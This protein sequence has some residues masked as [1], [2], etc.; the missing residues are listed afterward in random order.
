M[1]DRDGLTVVTGIHFTKSTLKLLN[2]ITFLFDP[3]W[4]A[5]ANNVPTFP[6]SFFHVKSIHEIGESEVSEKPL[7]FYNSQATINKNAVT[8]GVLN[9]VADNIT[10]KP[11]R[12]TLEVIIPYSNLSLLQT[13]YALQPY[14]YGEIVNILSSEGEDTA[15]NFPKP[16]EYL[17]VYINLIKGLLNTLIAADYTSLGAFTQSVLST[18]D[19]NKN[20][21][22]AMWRN[23]AI[24]KFKNWNDWRYKYVALT[25]YDITKVSEEEGVYE[26]TLTLREIPILTVRGNAGIKQPLYKNPIIEFTGNTI[27]SILNG[28]EGS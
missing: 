8:G 16:P 25:S 7:L 23:R 12:Y 17:S 3:S 24:L 2:N 22:E 20:S 26:A 18:P 13:S 9:V 1:E 14:Q 10:I 6:V 21:L 4:E 15:Y 19:Y 27:K 5:G 11:K 28:K